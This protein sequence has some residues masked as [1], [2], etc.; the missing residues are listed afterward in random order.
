MT[1][2]IKVIEPCWSEVIV[3][4]L[5]WWQFVLVYLKFDSAFYSRAYFD[6]SQNIQTLA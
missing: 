1:V 5:F 3:G 6:K 2:I 4:A